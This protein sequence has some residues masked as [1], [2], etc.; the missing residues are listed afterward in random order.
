MD[1]FIMDTNESQFTVH[2]ANN[3]HAIN[4]PLRYMVKHS[5]ASVKWTSIGT[6]NGLSV[7]RYQAINCNKNWVIANWTIGNEFPVNSNPNEQIL[8]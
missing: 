4:K 6:G 3:D 5:H 1:I 7:G 2:A 8:Y